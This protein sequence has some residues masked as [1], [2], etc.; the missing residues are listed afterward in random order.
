[1][2]EKLTPYAIALFM[3][4]AERRV[5]A[6]MNP[7]GWYTAGQLRTTGRLLWELNDFRR[8]QRGIAS[9]IQLVFPDRMEPEAT[10]IWQL[11]SLGEQVKDWVIRFGEAIVVDGCELRRFIP[12]P[13][14]V[15]DGTP[16]CIRCGQIDDE[17]YHDM[18]LCQ[19]VFGEA[20]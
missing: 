15:N 12:Y 5:I 1:M 6:A 3:T 14:P 13:G 10:R 8:E 4:K 16:R 9:T 11:S 19:L 17:P 7:I 20:P 18:D 2:G